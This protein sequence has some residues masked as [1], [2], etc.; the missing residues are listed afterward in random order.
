[1]L[2][3]KPSTF[4]LNSYV[5]KINIR[6]VV[7][8][9][10]T[11]NQKQNII[12]KY[13]RENKSQRAIHRETGI[14]RGTIR[15]YIKQY[16]KAQ[17]ELLSSKQISVAEQTDLIADIVEVPKYNVANREKRKLNDEIITKLK[18]YLEENIFKQQNHQK[19]QQKRIIDM[20][21]ALLAAG[22]D[23]GYTTVRN[24]VR[25]IMNTSKEAFIRME[26]AP[27]DV[28]EFD[29]GD[30]CINVAGVLR[31]FQMAVFT[32]AYSNYRY[33]ILFPKQKTADFVEAHALFF[34]HIGGVYRTIVYDNM[35]VAV[36][37]FVGISEKEPTE[38]L[39]K[40]S[41]YYQFS[42]RFCN[43]AKGN[44]KGHV[45]KSVDFI[46]RR[47]FSDADHFESLEAANEH[48]IKT[49]QRL[50]CSAQ[51]LFKNGTAF[52]R[53]TVEKEFLFRSMP[54]YES[55]RIEYSR[56]D[57]YSTVSIDTC[58]YSVPDAYVNKFI[59]TKVYTT[60]IRCYYESELIA[61]HKRCYGQREWSMN[62]N[63]YLKTFIRKPG[64]L[65]NSLALKQ[66]EGDL[67]C[68]YNKYFKGKEKAF[69]ELMLLHREYS[70]ESIK[71]SI[72]KVEKLSPN[73][74]DIEKIKVIC[75]RTGVYD[76][77]TSAVPS[78]IL[79]KSQ[80]QLKDYGALMYVSAETFIEAGVVT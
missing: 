74:I 5:M 80:E 19:K 33:A 12:I 75:Q 53:V 70:L 30:I 2:I 69:I 35:K 45:E 3:Q 43:V 28:C 62:I 21:L 61:E 7:W 76:D 25:K 65:A 26:Y 1:M 52:E 66:T 71:E 48:L 20:H 47:A 15:K 63:H 77:T 27:G 72:A 49:C 58:R 56:V 22:Y 24:A 4:K 29:W 13:H 14:D 9:L 57:K 51:I 60:Q 32:A 31:K 36:R 78:A 37:K 8:R 40:L 38:A 54:K 39:S 64:A 46:R 10:I 42:F 55:A 11:L 16:E 44:E 67:Q 41:M 59:V 79:E 6:G 73:D 34:E 50:N 17:Q 18:E 23:I 68:I